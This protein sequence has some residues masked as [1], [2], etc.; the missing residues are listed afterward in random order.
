M[1]KKEPER[2]FVLEEGAA[3][4][5]ALAL[6]IMAGMNISAKRQLGLMMHSTCFLPDL[7]HCSL[8]FWHRST[9]GIGG[10]PGASGV[11]IHGRQRVRMQGIP[12][13]PQ[14]GHWGFSWKRLITTSWVT[15][16]KPS[17]PRASSKPSGWSGGLEV[18]LS[19]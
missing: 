7:Q 1:S 6:A 14:R 5:I 11:A 17:H 19:P 12:W 18:V 15:Q 13:L 3:V 2:R 8:L 16:K 10:L 9:A 4:L